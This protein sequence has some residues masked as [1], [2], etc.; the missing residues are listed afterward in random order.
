M[1]ILLRD[2]RAGVFPGASRVFFFPRMQMVR[3]KRSTSLKWRQKI[4]FGGREKS[5]PGGGGGVVGVSLRHRGLFALRMDGRVEREVGVLGV[6]TRTRWGSGQL[7]SGHGVRAGGVRG[8]EGVLRVL[9]QLGYHNCAEKGA[10]R[11]Q[12]VC[13]RVAHK[14]KVLH[15]CA[16]SGSS[17]TLGCGSKKIQTGAEYK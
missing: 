17:H 10:Q 5:P 9:C 1:F 4:K 14:V 15:V 2:F 12:N 3:W 7:W 8:G 16:A 11:V 6:R 13:R